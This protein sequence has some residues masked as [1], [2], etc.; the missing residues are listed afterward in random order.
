MS[1][2][3]QQAFGRVQGEC[4]VMRTVVGPRGCGRVCVVLMAATRV[5]K[6]VSMVYIAKYTRLDVSFD[7]SINLK[8]RRLSGLEMRK[9]MV[10]VTMIS[11]GIIDAGVAERHVTF[12]MS[13]GGRGVTRA[14]V[15][16][17]GVGMWR[18]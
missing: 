14:L 17:S 2:C 8:I 5:E 6:I 16:V 15:E 11:A 3:T 18:S 7:M 13:V 12:D 4:A 1:V 9:S 10:V